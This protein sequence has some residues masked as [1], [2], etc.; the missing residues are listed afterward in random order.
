MK[1]GYVVVYLANVEEALDFYR[2][3]FALQIRMKH[4]ID[5]VIAYGELEMEGAILGFASHWLGELN[6]GR[7]YQSVSAEGKPFGQTLVFVTED[8]RAALARAIAAG[9][10][11]VGAPNLKPCGQTV[12][13][14]RAIEG[15][16]IELRSPPAC[17]ATSVGA[18]HDPVPLRP[19]K[20]KENPTARENCA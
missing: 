12:A 10:A 8:V 20:L 2:D 9:A 17:D 1:L 6:L 11:I 13:Y 4:E 18:S 5:G 19:A 15:T 16:L 14:V 7:Q 3:A